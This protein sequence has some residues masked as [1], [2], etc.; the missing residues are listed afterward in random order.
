MTRLAIV[1]EKAAILLFFLLVSTPSAFAQT[2][3]PTPVLPPQPVPPL[4][5][6]QQLAVQ[7]LIEAEIEESKEIDDRIETEVEDGF[8]WTLGLLNTL[9]T[10]LIAIPI[11][12][13]LAAWALRRSIV[14]ELVSETSKQLREETEKAVQEQLQRQVAAE[15]QKQIEEFKQQLESSRRDLQ[16]EKDHLQQEKN[17]IFQELNRLTPSIIQEEFVSPQVQK[18][19]KELT[20][21]IE[22]LSSKNAQLILTAE[23]YLQQGNAFYLERRY[24][25]AVTAFSKAIQ[26]NPDLV[27]AWLS[28]A[29]TFRRLKRY[30]EA[31]ADNEKVIQIA[32]T[33]LWGW[34]GKG[35]VL[36][37]TH[38]FEE[39]IPVL[40]QAAK[41]SPQNYRP[42][43]SQAYALTK[44]GRYKEAAECLNQAI[45]CYPNSG[46][47]YYCK[48]YY[49]IAQNQLDLAIDNL[50]KAIELNAY[51][52]EILET[53]SD[54]DALK[55]ND[56]FRQEVHPLGKNI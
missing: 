9:I 22:A 39:A 24:E 40:E 19:I 36:R 18:R 37:D 12:T 45:A 35:F 48:A 54:F 11:V 13:A 5:D 32:P 10:V 16:Q 31:L 3:A 47:N 41:I 21:R 25:D 51:Y 15:L 53:D 44:L 33:N 55:M 20:D 7:E 49:H 2:P 46:G 30:D 27:D 50:K 1:R 34:L 42:W 23:D 14:A 6:K 28:R 56:R 8:G 43:R 17:R 26:L 29:K 4:S 38:R 52:S